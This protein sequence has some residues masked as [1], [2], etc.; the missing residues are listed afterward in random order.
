[1]HVYSVCMRTRVC[2]CVCV[3]VC[4][5]SMGFHDHDCPKKFRLKIHT[6]THTHTQGH[7]QKGTYT[8]HTHKH[9]HRH[10]CRVCLI[11]D[12]HKQTV[13]MQGST[14]LGVVLTPVRYLEMKFL[15]ASIP[16]WLVLESLKSGSTSV[17]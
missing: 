7:R 13:T 6:Y 2:V 14:I 9:S 17:P 4:V 12:L 16:F 10:T 3:R 15:V 1:M 5:C 11:S 8:H